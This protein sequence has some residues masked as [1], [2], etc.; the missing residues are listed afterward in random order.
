N[1]LSVEGGGSG[2]SY[3]WFREGAIPNGNGPNIIVDRQGYYSVQVV[4][5]TGC[6]IQSDSVFYIPLSGLEDPDDQII[7]K[8]SPNPTRDVITLLI[9]EALPD[10]VLVNVYNSEGKK[11]LSTFVKDN[12]NR[13]PISRLSRGMYFVEIRLS[14]K[15]RKIL[16]VIVN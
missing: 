9:S 3:Q 8:V 15:R 4:S 14:P 12:I 2:A 10:E 13:I 6:I 5:R 11:M 7:F 1:S 16:S